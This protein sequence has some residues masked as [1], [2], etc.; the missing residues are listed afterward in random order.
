MVLSSFS[1]IHINFLHISSFNPRWLIIWS[2]VRIPFFPL[3]SLS[4]FV[5]MIDLNVSANHWGFNTTNLWKSNR[6]PLFTNCLFIWLHCKSERVEFFKWLRRNVLNSPLEMIGMDLSSCHEGFA[7][8][9][10]I[11]VCTFSILISRIKIRSLDLFQWYQKRMVP[12]IKWIYLLGGS[13]TIQRPEWHHFI[14]WLI[15]VKLGL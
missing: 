4:Y 7:I 13:N 12:S 1:Q 9:S 15:F 14:I 8:M 10:A 6:K 11:S 5:E 2:K 3:L